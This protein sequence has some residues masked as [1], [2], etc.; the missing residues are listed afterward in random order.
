MLIYDEIGNKN[1]YEEFVKIKSADE[2]STMLIH[3]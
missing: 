3:I 2:Y 1:Q